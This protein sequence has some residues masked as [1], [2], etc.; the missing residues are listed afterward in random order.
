LTASQ[1]R[2]NVVAGCAAANSLSPT[3]DCGLTQSL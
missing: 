2:E 3:T 1:V